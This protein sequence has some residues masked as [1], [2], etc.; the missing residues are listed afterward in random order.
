MLRSK[1]AWALTALAVCALA[2]PALSLAG[3]NTIEVDAQL[4]GKNEVPG[5]G[6][7]K[8]KGD[9]HI[10][11]KPT[12]NKVCFELEVK[13]LDTIT[14]SHIHKGDADQAGTV[15]VTLIDSQIQ[16]TGS[17]EGCVKSV[18]SKLIDKIAAKPERFYVNVH[19]LD[20]PEGAIRGQLQG[21]VG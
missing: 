19:T 4:K 20:Y 1:L 3:R 15:K 14:A 21:L 7:P 10:F 9:V 17:Y 5:P 11:L 12:K 18:R 8:G 13:N 2:V 6:S 16:G